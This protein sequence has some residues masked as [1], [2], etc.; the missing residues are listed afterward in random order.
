MIGW[1]SETL[2]GDN[3]ILSL[4]F[5]NFIKDTDR[6]NSQVQYLLFVYIDDS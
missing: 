6:P 3:S 2:I 4:C 1:T 5:H